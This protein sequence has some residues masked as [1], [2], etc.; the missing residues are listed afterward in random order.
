MKESSRSV[1]HQVSSAH[2]AKV[3]VDE[4][5]CLVSHVRPE[6]AA[7]DAVPRWVVLFVEFFL[8]ERRNVLLNVVLLEG[9]RGAVYRILLHVL[10]H[11]G[12]LNDCLPF[13]HGDC[14]LCT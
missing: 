6:V 4:V 11:V 1:C 5:F 7:D 9:L 10:R 13:C 8:D 12:I 3:K 14:G 2:L